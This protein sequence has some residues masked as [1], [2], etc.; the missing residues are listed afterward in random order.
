MVEFFGT[1]KSSG[2]SP[3]DRNGCGFCLCQFWYSI[4]CDSVSG[5]FK[6]T[7]KNALDQLQCLARL[8]AGETLSY[9]ERVFKIKVVGTVPVPQPR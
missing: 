2:P 1:G 9:L 4:T 6:S 3:N 8:S 5:S 7:C